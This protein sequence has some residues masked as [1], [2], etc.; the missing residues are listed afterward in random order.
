MSITALK[1]SRSYLA[2]LIATG[3]IELRRDAKRGRIPNQT[4]NAPS[5]RITE[6]QMREAWARLQAGGNRAGIARSMGIER[7]L[8]AHHLKPSHAMRRIR[9]RHG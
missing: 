5:R 4:R 3:Q 7:T 2:R 8:L 6:A 9:N 1:V